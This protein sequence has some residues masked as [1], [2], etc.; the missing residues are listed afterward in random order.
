MLE[1]NF[2]HGKQYLSEAFFVLNILGSSAAK[3]MNS[4]PQPIFP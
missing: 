2:G 4:P 3:G 1:H